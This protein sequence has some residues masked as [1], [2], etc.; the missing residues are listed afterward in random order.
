M[1]Y[2]RKIFGSPFDIFGHG[3]MEAVNLQLVS[4]FRNNY[5]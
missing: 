3:G 2:F 1:K 4:S 5:I